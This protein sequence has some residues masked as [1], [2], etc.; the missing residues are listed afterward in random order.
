MRKIALNSQAAM[1]S[2]WQI[3]ELHIKYN[4]KVLAPPLGSL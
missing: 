3:E 1:P 4:T 2:T